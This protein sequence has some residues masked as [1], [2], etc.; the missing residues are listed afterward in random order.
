MSLQV[1]IAAVVR[2]AIGDIVWLLLSPVKRLLEVFK[3]A[4]ARIS[5]IIIRRGLFAHTALA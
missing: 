4:L 2:G 5:I 3:F 1:P